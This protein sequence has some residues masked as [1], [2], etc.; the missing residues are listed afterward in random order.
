MSQSCDYRLEC[1][2]HKRCQFQDEDHDK[3]DQTV[4]LE[5][6]V[7]HSGGTILTSACLDVLQAYQ[8]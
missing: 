4:F 8:R 3:K 6:L 5:R 2:R 1:F 7:P